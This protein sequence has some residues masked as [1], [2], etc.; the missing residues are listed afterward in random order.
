MSIIADMPS[1]LSIVGT[2]FFILLF[3]G[4][5]VIILTDDASSSKKIAWLLTI[6]LVPIIGL[7][8]YFVLGINF[9]R[10]LYKQRN[11]KKVIRA[12]DGTGNDSLRELITGEGCLDSIRPG[13]QELARLLQ[14]GGA[15]P[16]TSGN[17]VEV[18]TDGRLKIDIL[19]DDIRA[20]REYI[21]MEYFYFRKGESGR[22]VKELLMQ[23]AREGVK[24]RFIYENI[25]NFDISPRYYL[26]MRKAGVEVIRFTPVMRSILTIYTKLNYRDHRKIVIIDGKIGY[27]GGMNISDDYYKLWR[28]THLRITGNAIAGLQASFLDAYLTSG[29]KIS[30]EDLSE[31]GIRRLFPQIESRDNDPASPALVQTLPGDPDTRWPFLSMGYEWVMFNSRKYIYIQTPY[32]MPTDPVMEAM[33]AAALKGVDVRLMVPKKADVSILTPIN[34]SYFKECMDAGIRIFEKNGNF[35]HS[36]T[37]VCDDYLSMV[38]SSNLD[39]RS[40]E[41]SYEFNTYMYDEA[42]A[43]ENR[44]IFENDMTEC[45][46]LS[47]EK[48]GRI[49]WYKKFWY[50]MWRLLAPLL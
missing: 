8:L 16:V 42:L 22:K 47:P 7:I 3:A 33:K 29:G 48:W 23:K 5:I 41:L 39:Y 20:A 18:V 26:E 12:L 10:P 19:L 25:A 45:T 38:G 11:H 13:Y 50:A 1:I 36:K 49:G 21:H 17:E 24:V 2:A 40:L 32:L 15:S 27:T 31:E 28:D 14:R 44:A 6:T 43:K 37:F 4:T 34:R 46:E 9:R 30:D 35:I